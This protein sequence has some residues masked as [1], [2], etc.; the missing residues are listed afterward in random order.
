[1]PIFY[2]PHQDWMDG[3][4]GGVNGGVWQIAFSNGYCLHSKR[5]RASLTG[6]ACYAGY[7]GYENEEVAD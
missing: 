6:N 3:V 4:E 2:F 7:N 5:F 1:M